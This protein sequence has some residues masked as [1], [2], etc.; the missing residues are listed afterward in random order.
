MKAAETSTTEMLRDTCC[1][2]KYLHLA[3]TLP[4]GS[5]TSTPRS[6]AARQLLLTRDGASISPMK[7]QFVVVTHTNHQTEIPALLDSWVT[8][9]VVPTKDKCLSLHFRRNVTCLSAGLLRIGQ[10][11]SIS[12]NTVHRWVTTNCCF[13]SD[14]CP[15]TKST[16]YCQQYN[17]K[18][19]NVFV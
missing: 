2:V 18:P 10:V 16:L 11:S 14:L 4:F 3:S 9:N 5:L 19:N 15:S 17:T 8:Q 1:I 12:C 6:H 13:M 7:R